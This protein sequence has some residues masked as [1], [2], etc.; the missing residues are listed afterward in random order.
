M[1][2]GFDKKPGGSSLVQMVQ[3]GAE[4]EPGKRTLT[5]QL[6]TGAPVMRKADAAGGS[7]A[8]AGGSAGGGDA[9][10]AGPAGAAAPRSHHSK[11]TISTP[12]P[13]PDGG[14]VSDPDDHGA[15]QAAVAAYMQQGA[16][17][18]HDGAVQG[19]GEVGGDADSVHSAAA[20]G[21]SGTSGALPHLG[22]IQ[23]LF[24]RHDVSNVQAH[25]DGAAAEGSRA[26]GA[27]AF[28]TG[29]HVAFAGPPSLHTAAHEAAHVVQQ[30]GGVQLKSGVGQVGDAYEQHADAVADR[31][32]QGKSAA[33][34][35]DPYAGGG[36][37]G[38]GAVQHQAVQRMEAAEDSGGGA[39]HSS[40]GGAAAPAAAKAKHHYEVELKAWI[41]FAHVVDPEEPAR[42][43]DWLDTLSTIGGSILDDISVLNAKLNYEFHSYYRGDG[44]TGYPGGYRVLTKAAFDFDGTS[45]TGFT[46]VGTYGASH[47]DWNYHA[48]FDVTA[49]VGPFRTTLYSKDI[50]KKSGTESKTA[51]S[52]TSGA[53][54][55]ASSFSLGMS[56]A[57]PLVMTWAPT[58]D[59]DLTGKLDSSGNMAISYTTDLFPSH[60]IQVKRDG[61]VIKEEVVNDPSGINPFGPIAAINIGHRLTSHTNHG[62]TKAP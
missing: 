50:T 14:V 22:T 31:V 59:S 58:I 62:T 23:S 10:A 45:I 9:A 33:D 60:G 44:H 18:K 48:W 4:L 17:H 39:A 6:G 47:R 1:S 42:L 46:H 20:H 7:A 36:G 2:G 8:A 29:S 25:T 40:A 34:L 54:A 38:G 27:E 28:A 43:H 37:G 26:M 13:K 16:A 12:K 51:T 5:E 52:A 56:S 35:L 53:S 61:G 15:A 41:P 49:G 32:V 11:L 3:G 30:R 24:G 19:S 57:N 21:I 55:G